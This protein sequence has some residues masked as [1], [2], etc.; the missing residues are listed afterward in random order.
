MLTRKSLAQIFFISCMLQGCSSSNGKST[1]SSLSGSPG[2]CQAIINS[3][4]RTEIYVNDNT[5]VADLDQYTPYDIVIITFVGNVPGKFDS[6]GDPVIGITGSLAGTPPYAKKGLLGL[7]TGRNRQPLYLA[8]RI[9]LLQQ[10][11]KCVLLALGGATMQNADYAVWATPDKTTKLAQQTVAIAADLGIDGIDIEFEDS[12]ALLPDSFGPTKYNGIPFITNLTTAIST[13]MQSAP[14]PNKVLIHTPQPPYL[15]TYTAT[16]SN[17]YVPVGQ[18]YNPYMQLMS[19]VGDKIT[20]LNIQYY[21]NFQWNNPTALIA[22]IDKIIAGFDGYAGIPAIKLMAGKPVGQGLWIPGSGTI[23]GPTQSYPIESDAGTRYPTP[24]APGETPGKDPCNTQGIT[25]SP[26]T[27]GFLDLTTITQQIIAPLKAKYPSFGGFYGWQHRSDALDYWARRIFVSLNRTPTNIPAAIPATTYKTVSGDFGY[28]VAQNN[29]ISLATLIAANPN[30][31]FNNLQPG[32]TLTIPGAPSPWN[33]IISAG[34]TCDY[35]KQLFSLPS[36]DVL[37]NANGSS[38]TS[39]FCSGLQLGQ[40][41]I[42]PVG[43][44]APF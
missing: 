25:N 11:G 38:N 35:L 41:L 1:P 4:G 17:P 3:P 2:G 12:A 30:V 39:A 18:K 32:T 31:N 44:L 6:V 15:E 14:M 34:D 13:A 28:R 29:G 42:I 37:A 43:Q 23:T 27:A 16:P 26:Q 5:R 24:C 10:A 9:P 22:Q 40:V 21:N 19:A 20:W 33:W 36:Y 8:D 7:Q